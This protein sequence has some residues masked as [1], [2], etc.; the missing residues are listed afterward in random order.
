MVILGGWVFLT[1]EVPLYGMQHG[2]VVRNAGPS[3]HPPPLP[4]HQ[5]TTLQRAIHTFAQ[6]CCGLGTFIDSFPCTTCA[7]RSK[8][9]KGG[10]R[11][12]SLI[13]TPP[14]HQDLSEEICL[15]PYGGP[16][17]GV[18]FL[19]ARYP[20]TRKGGWGGTEKSASRWF[21]S[22]NISASSAPCAPHVRHHTRDT[23]CIRRFAGP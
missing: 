18:C 15:G 7:Q 22:F 10:Y 11:G 8:P 23:A 12:T 2:T 4:D 16:T 5:K 1:S 9:R 17:G 3:I 20:C 6:R 13:R 19:R 21:S 14:P